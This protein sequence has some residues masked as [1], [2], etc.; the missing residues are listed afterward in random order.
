M[1]SM[2][3]DIINGTGNW[4]FGVARWIYNPLIIQLKEMGYHVGENLF[5]CHYDWRKNNNYIMVNYL[6]PMIKEVGERFP[7]QKIDL[8]CHSMGGLVARCYIQ[9]NDY[10][11]DIDKLILLGTPEEGALE[12]YY[13]WSTGRLMSGKEGNH[14]YQILAKGYTWILLRLLNISLGL[15]N[16]EKIHKTFPSIGELIPSTDYGN[17][18]FYEEEGGEYKPIPRSFMRYEN[19]FLDELNEKAYLLSQR[20]GGVYSIVGYDFPTP[21]YLV[22]DGKKFLDDYEEIILDLVESTEGDGTVLLQSAILAG[23][24]NYFIKASHKG[25]LKESFP[26]IKEIYNLE[27]V[28]GFEEIAD[29]EETTLHIIFT[30]N[31]NIIIDKDEKTIATILGGHMTTDYDY[32]YE[33]YP[34]N[35]QWIIIN[36]IE[37]GM[38]KVKIDNEDDNNIDMMIMVEGMGKRDNQEEI[39]IHK[40]NFEF[41]IEVY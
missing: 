38:Y 2:G 36:G 41:Y 30:E 8:I 18:L 15:E 21:E 24:N 37:K 27:D 12:A 10:Q 9:G 1:G 25:M 19:H 33:K 6:K 7:N 5:V 32:H 39:K 22:V 14:F 23:Y 11:Y 40:K 17:I 26:Y 28:K 31:L 3:S 16:L 4:S 20:V 29:V 13:L 35:H 34:M